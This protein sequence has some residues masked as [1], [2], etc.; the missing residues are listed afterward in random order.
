MAHS[1]NNTTCL[2]GLTAVRADL[3][4]GVALFCAGGFPSILHDCF[5]MCAGRFLTIKQVNCNLCAEAEIVI[6]SDRKVVVTGHQIQ[7]LR[8]HPGNFALSKAMG[9]ICGT[10][11]MCVVDVYLR[12]IQI[13][14]YS[15]LQQVI[16]R[17]NVIFSVVLLRQIQV[18]LRSAG[19]V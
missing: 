1:R 19:F 14:T 13:G 18:Q 8:E 9:K 10:K 15:S 4:A 6:G 3:I 2:Y 12:V 5:F 7:I 16:R 11:N 17:A